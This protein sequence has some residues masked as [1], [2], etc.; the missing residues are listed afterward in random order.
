[1]ELPAIQ[2]EDG[3][4]IPLGM[5]TCRELLSRI[6]VMTVDVESTGYPVGHPL[7]WLR[8]VQLGDSRFAIV[9]DAQLHKAEIREFLGYA[10]TLH[11]HSAPADLVPLATAGLVD[12]DS[13]WDRMIDTVIYAKLSDPELSGEDDGL[14]DLARIVL[15]NSLCYSADRARAEYFKEEKWLTNTN[16]ETPQA[17]SGWSN[18]DYE[19]PV[20]ITYAASDVIDTARIAQILPKPTPA[21]LERE[22][23][24]ERITARI[25]L[26]GMRIDP[27]QTDTLHVEASVAKEESVKIING[28]GIESPGSKKALAQLLT[29]TYGI[30]LPHT[31]PSMRF[32]GGQPSVKSEVLNRINGFEGPWNPLIDSILEYRKWENRLGLFLN[33]YRT[34]VRQ[35]DGR[36]RPVVYTLEADTGRMSCRRPNLQQVPRA[37][38]FRSCLTAD[39]GTLLVSADLSGVELRVAAALAQDESLINLIMSGEDVHALIAAVVYGSDWTKPQRYKVKRA[40][41][42]WLYGAGIPKLAADQ[43]VEPEVIQ[44]MIGALT[45]LAPGLPTWTRSVRT[46]VQGGLSVASAY[47][48]RPIYLDPQMS[49]KAP[50]YLIQGT[51]REIL[52][53][54]LLR[55]DQGPYGGG[56]VLPVHDEI[57]AVVAEDHAQDALSCLV[58]CMETELYGMPITAVVN[59]PSFAWQDAE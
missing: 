8:T 21:L 9:F 14:K 46:A 42:G 37:G 4:P 51:A 43:A 57:V 54:A 35:G 53:D 1:M 13:A 26:D 10:E 12:W 31:D 20:M 40:V 17:R 15:E 41:F 11:A 5:S 58:G 48:G 32:P 52:V 30:Q 28:F 50:N 19:S 18:C 3:E 38:G 39:S 44:R 29:D 36:A 45:A 6:K 23:G 16:T 27:V 33:P 59:E 49:H 47:S 56:V 7:Y 25:A 24:A 22:R 2:V 34:L 55:W